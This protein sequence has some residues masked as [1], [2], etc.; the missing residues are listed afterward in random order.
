MS[1]F[2]VFYCSI[3]GIRWSRDQ[4]KEADKKGKVGIYKSPSLLPDQE[5]I[6]MSWCDKRSRWM[7]YKL[8][9]RGAISSDS[10]LPR[11]PRK[12]MSCAE[13]T[14]RVPNLSLTA[15]FIIRKE[16]EREKWQD[17]SWEM[18]PY[19]SFLCSSPSVHFYIKTLSPR[20]CGQAL[21]NRPL[22]EREKRRLH[23]M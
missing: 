23:C 7:E 21:E 2:I 20:H 19:S 1:V 6:Q 3:G 8:T 22:L 10:T 13:L 11:M 18:F 17:K 12:H 4:W 14:G 15:L 16:E 9:V 5:L